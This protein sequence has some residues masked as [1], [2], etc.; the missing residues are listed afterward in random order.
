MQGSPWSTASGLGTEEGLRKPLAALVLQ[1]LVAEADAV[2]TPQ[3]GLSSPSPVP[4]HL[5]FIRKS[6]HAHRSNSWSALPPPPSTPTRYARTPTELA[7]FL[8]RSHTSATQRGLSPLSIDRSVQPRPDSPPS[9]PSSDLSEIVNYYAGDSS[10]SDSPTLYC[11]RPVRR[12]HVADVLPPPPEPASG[13]SQPRCTP[14]AGTLRRRTPEARVRT[15]DGM[16]WPVGLPPL[17]QR[18]RT[19]SLVRAAS[20]APAKVRPPVIA[21]PKA[22]LEKPQRTRAQSSAGRVQRSISRDSDNKSNTSAEEA[23]Y[24]SEQ[25]QY[26]QSHNDAGR[27]TLD[28]YGNMKL[29]RPVANGGNAQIY[30]GKLTLPNGHKIRVAVKV[31][32]QKNA[33]TE[34]VRR[35]LNREFRIWNTLR[36]KNV[37]PLLGLCEDLAGAAFPALVAPFCKFGHVGN[38][39]EKRPWANRHELIIGVGAGLQFLHES[40]VVHGD[41]KEENVLIDK[42]GVP[43]IC[44]FGLSRILN[45]AGF[46]TTYAGG[47]VPYM[48]PELFILISDNDRAVDEQK[49]PAP[50]TTQMSDVYAFALVA[51][52]ILTSASFRDR[53]GNIFVKPPPS[54]PCGRN[55]HGIRISRIC[56]GMFGIFWISVGFLSRGQGRISER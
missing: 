25:L 15:A 28:E 36:H 7:R 9:S 23:F 12:I 33:T 45:C 54:M 49:V 26:L 19:S 29:H 53:Q 14:G 13:A 31:I 1:Q 38:Y 51:L 17:P 32:L 16:R 48:A 44:D 10:P 52:K 21:A 41:L 20:V 40:G 37:L 27:L 35:R 18:Q 8:S 47:T 24:D 46:T 39:L 3:S 34:Q 11:P 30:R 50:L 43:C 5:G 22:G 56:D 55:T 42:N 2:A 4:A 6:N